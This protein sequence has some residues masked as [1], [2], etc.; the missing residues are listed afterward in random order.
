MAMKSI[1]S[2]LFAI[3]CA[4]SAPAEAWAESDSL[5]DRP[6]EISSPNLE[7]TV[8]GLASSPSAIF[9][10]Y[11]PRIPSDMTQT[12]PLVV[13]GSPSRPILKMSLRKCVLLC[14]TVNMRGIVNIE[15]VSPKRSCNKQFLM[16]MDLRNSDLL[17]SDTYDAINA[18]ICF[19]KGANGKDVLSINA[20]ARRGRSYSVTPDAVAGSIFNFLKAQIPAI[21]SA[22]KATLQAQASKLPKPEKSVKPERPEKKAELRD[23]LDEE[24][25]QASLDANSA[26]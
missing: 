17:L 14:A 11:Q 4:V 1:F 7:Q 10:N 8:D 24:E 20:E 9:R 19:K 25:Q 3:T 12:S 6:I 13:S 26:A 2:I 22:M 21:T 23:S 15:S 16:T 5:Q 18:D